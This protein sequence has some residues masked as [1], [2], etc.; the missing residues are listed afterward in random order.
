MDDALWIESS[1]I[2]VSAG[3]AGWQ[4]KTLHTYRKADRRQNAER[5]AQDRERE[6]RRARR[7]SWE[8]V[9]K[10]IQAVLRRVEDVESEARNRPLDRQAMARANL[11]RVQRRLE[12]LSDRCPPPLTKPLQTVA[13]AVAKLQ[14]VPVPTDTDVQRAYTKAVES[15]PPCDPAPEFMASAIAT[16]AIGQYQ[17]AVELHAAVMAAWEAV[18]TERG[19]ES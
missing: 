8:P 16:E 7:D 2:V 5:A 1:A 10:E 19:G 6:D 9:F 17:A 14:T 3:I 18:Q 15:T 4:H 12:T 13:A 11:G